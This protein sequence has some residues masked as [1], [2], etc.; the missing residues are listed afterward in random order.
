MSGDTW[1]SQQQ[2]DN[3]WTSSGADWLPESGRLTTSVIGQLVAS[4]TCHIGH[5]MRGQVVSGCEVTS[6]TTD[7]S[8]KGHS[9]NSC[10]MVNTGVF[11]QVM[12]DGFFLFLFFYSTNYLYY[13]WWYFH[14]EVEHLKCALNVTVLMQAIFFLRKEYY[15][16]CESNRIK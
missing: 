12:M 3:W 2:L 16:L 1:S 14:Y 9:V 8:L 11:S 7:L 13:L 4:V 5:V 15:N 10:L 6:G